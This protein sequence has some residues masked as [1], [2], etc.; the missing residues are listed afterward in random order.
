MNFTPQN[1]RFGRASCFWKHFF[2]EGSGQN[3]SETRDLGRECLF[4]VDCV[5]S[6]RSDGCNFMDTVFA[7]W[8]GGIGGGVWVGR[9]VY[10][11]RDALQDWICTK[12]KRIGSECTALLGNAWSNQVPRLL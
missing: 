5:F 11:G 10:T 9:T 4:V 1:L 3:L 8:K 12:W 2:V 7:C 6:V